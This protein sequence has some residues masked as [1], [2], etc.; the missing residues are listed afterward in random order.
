MTIAVLSGSPAINA[1]DPSSC[2]SSDQRGVV[3]PQG[4]GCDIGAY[5]F[6]TGTTTTLVS[7]PNPSAYGESVT[8]TATVADS[9]AGSV[10]TGTVTFMDGATPLGIATLDGTAHAV[11][12]TAALAA[13]S[14]EITAVYGGDT[15][16][17]TSTS[18]PLTQSVVQAATTTTITGDAPDPSVTGQAVTVTYTIIPVA[19]G[20]GTP[21]GD[22]TVS[23]GT[24][25]CTG[26]VAAGGCSITFAI[27]G[28]GTLTATYAGDAN[29]T[30]SV[31]PG[32]THTVN[33]AATTTA[34]TVDAPDPSLAGQTVTVSY[35]VTVAAPGSGTPTGNVTVTDGASSCTGTVAAGSCIVALTTAGAHTLTATYAGDAN[36]VGS[37]SA[38][39]SHTVDKSGTTTAIT[40]DTPDPSVI[41]QIVTVS[42][43]VT[44]TAP[45]SGTPAGNVTVSDGVNSCTSTVA[46]GSC[47]LALA[48]SG[49]RTLTAT[50]AGDANFNGSSGTAAHAVLFQYLL[51]LSTSGSGTV[52]GNMI[53][54]EGDGINC[55]SN[56]SE[57]YNQGTVVIL[58]AV[59]AAGW[60]FKTWAGDPDCSDGQVTVNGA[61][62]CEAVFVL[63]N[64]VTFPA[65]TGNGDITLVTNS[66]GCGFT[67]WGAKTEAQT[68]DDAAF[69]YPY[70][71]VEF[72][73]NCA[74]ADVTITFPGSVIGSTYRKYGPTT[75]GLVSTSAWYTLGNVTDNG[76]NSVTLHLHDGQLGDDTGVDGIIVDQG[77][78]AQPAGKGPVDVPTMTEWGMIVFMVLAGLGAVRYLRK[79]GVIRG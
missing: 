5:E 77:G 76:N 9:E 51:G 8:F 49:P 42:Y 73:L 79:T 58:T 19:P 65:A 26:T 2:P 15:S 32:E 43:S 1:G 44:A 57:T 61:M 17:V 30:G 60:N 59:P 18:A 69:E 36:Y 16:F 27:P 3:R 46:A 12:S 39:E 54:V 20:S 66:P 38:G 37:V 48:T 35:G 64:S 67:S 31:S 56:C 70:G 53:G 75:P 34:I 22:V 33:K 78:V 72:T 14:H 13:G 11:F 47:S 45:G 24:N 62:T 10:P 71:L 23:D 41:G 52:T 63:N 55:G 29:F 21:T 6:V 68:G 28:T 50:Y 25:T 74:D 7:A 4:A 40:S